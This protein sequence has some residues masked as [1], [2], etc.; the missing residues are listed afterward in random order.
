M[1]PSR[2]PELL[3]SEEETLATQVSSVFNPAAY[4]TV[5]EGVKAMHPTLSIMNTEALSQSDHVVCYDFDK[6]IICGHSHNLIINNPEYTHRYLAAKVTRDIQESKKLFAELAK[7][8]LEEAGGFNGAESILKNIRENLAGSIP[9][10]ITSFT[11]FPEL[12]LPILRN[13]G[14]TDAELN[15]IGVIGGFPRAGSR[16]NKNEHLNAAMMLTGARFPFLI[17]DSETNI[18]AALAVYGPGSA[19]LVPEASR[20]GSIDYTD[21]NIF[22][23]AGV[24]AV[25]IKQEIE[26]EFYRQLSEIDKNLHSFTGPTRE[27]QGQ[28]TVDVIKDLESIQQYIIEEQNHT[29]QILNDPASSP[30]EIMAKLQSF[31]R[32]LQRIELQHSEVQHKFQSLNA[33]KTLQAPSAKPQLA[34]LITSLQNIDAGNSPTS[35][36]LPYCDTPNKQ[37]SSLATTP[38]YYFPDFPAC[39]IDCST[40]AE[41]GTIY[42]AAILRERSGSPQIAVSP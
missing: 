22:R 18:Q 31:K 27:P 8:V 41:A 39:I 12:V 7:E 11:N 1:R 28:K 23:R 20:E 6:S 4:E 38:R 35:R 15:K 40:A 33:G 24:K 29:K 30:E 42:S 32:E 10:V 14:L 2:P 25:I 5:L 13:L 3:T 9:I 19:L 37:T 16:G 21:A 17:D 26:A 36:Q 34:H